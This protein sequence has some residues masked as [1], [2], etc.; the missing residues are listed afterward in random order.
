MYIYNFGAP[1]LAVR[2]LVSKKR[3]GVYVYDNFATCSSRIP[4]VNKAA[5]LKQKSR[6]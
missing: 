5:P 6:V 3:C 1:V 2:K 4:N